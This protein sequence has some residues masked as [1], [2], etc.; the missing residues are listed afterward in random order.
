MKLYIKVTAS[1]LL[2]LLSRT[3]G[4]QMPDSVHLFFGLGTNFDFLNSSFKLNNVYGELKYINDRVFTAGSTVATSAPAGS[5][6]PIVAPG[7]LDFRLELGGYRGRALSR[8]DSDAFLSSLYI[9]PYAP[10]TGDSLNIVSQRIK[11]QRRFSLD[12]LS[13]YAIPGITYNINNNVRIGLGAYMEMYRVENSVLYSNSEVIESDSSRVPKTSRVVS[14]EFKDSVGNTQ[15]YGYFGLAIPLT[16]IEDK[17][18][19]RFKAVIGR[20]ISGSAY[21]PYPGIE[22]GKSFYLFD[23]SIME[24]HS[25]FSVIANIRGL[26][27][28]SLPIWSVYLTKQFDV[29][30]LFE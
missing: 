7:T 27:P 21:L 5:T 19:I 17:V 11:A 13:L 22:Q 20:V 12:Q 23:V 8:I 26:F 9:N 30:K 4:A 18:H 2:S 3:A 10:V 15:T 6:A 16:I 25:K 29:A 14:H 1:I 28:N 24:P